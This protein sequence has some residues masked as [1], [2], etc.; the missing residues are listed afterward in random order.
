MSEP[1]VDTVVDGNSLVAAQEAAPVAS[2]PS[3][4]GGSLLDAGKAEAA[5]P[6]PSGAW[7]NERGEFGENW[8]DRL[9]AEL[10]DSKQILGQ[11]KDV[12]GALK[13]LVNQQRLLGKKADAV[14]IPKD[15]ASPE[16]VAAFRAKLGVPETPEAYA[17]KPKDLPE[18]MQ[19]DEAYAKELNAAAHEAGI[20]PAQA[21]KLMSKYASLEAQN[22]QQAE[23][24]AKASYEASRKELAEAWGDK[25]ET[26]KSVATR[27]A[28]TLGLDPNSKGLSDPKVVI[29]L[30][31]AA[32]LI[33]DDKIVSSDSSATVQIGKSK[34]MDIMTNPANPMHSKYQAGDAS[35]TSLVT[36]LLKNG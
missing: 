35:V 33:S 28:Q 3:P 24:Q 30:E 4:A 20:T 9:P 12:N 11:F 14:L 10:Q 25:F 32:R 7:V 26:N 27:M 2:S 22:A 23:L 6:S 15:D 5:T 16:E 1:I 19:W 13:T 36:D 17:L 8:L 29:A 31:R 34:A 18:G 21:E